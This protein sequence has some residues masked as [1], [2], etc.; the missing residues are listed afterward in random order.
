MATVT[1]AEATTPYAHIG[2]KAEPGGLC[3][4]DPYPQN[5]TPPASYAISATMPPMK[6]Y[7][8]IAQAG[9]VAEALYLLGWTVR[10]TPTAR[11]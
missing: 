2:L 1:G 6:T 7:A 8:R 9:G 3:P 11:I 10:G 5:G 4:G